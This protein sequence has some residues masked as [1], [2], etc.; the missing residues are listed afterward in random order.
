MDQKPDTTGRGGRGATPSIRL[1][2]MPRDTNPQGSIFGGVILSLI[3]QAA[4]VEALRCGGGGRG[5]RRRWVT[6]AMNGVEFHEPVQVGDVVSLYTAVERQGRTSLT[7]KVDVEAQAGDDDT[8]RRV[9]TAQVVLVS[10][11]GNGTP[12]PIINEDKGIR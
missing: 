6:V 3:D 7:V 10:V 2:M 12:M 4:F 8:A 1:V 5:G 9:T 11:D